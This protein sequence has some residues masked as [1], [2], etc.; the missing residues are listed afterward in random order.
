[1]SGAETRGLNPMYI[2]LVLVTLTVCAFVP[3][4]AG[5]PSLAEVSK[6]REEI[7]RSDALWLLK[8]EFEEPEAVMAALMER[9]KTRVNYSL[10]Q[11]GMRLCR[12][13]AIYGRAKQDPRIVAAA[14]RFA[15]A[16]LRKHAT[17]SGAFVEYDRNTWL[18]S[19]E[20]W[21]TIPWGTAFCGNRAFEAWMELKTDFTPEERA[22]WRQS[23]EK[24][25]RWIHRNPVLGGYVFNNVI[26]LCG[27]LWRIGREFDHPEW[28]RAALEVAERRIR[29]DVDEEGWIQGENGG[30][31]GTYQLIGAR[32]LSQFAWEAKAPVL[33][34]AVRRIFARSAM[35]YATPTLEWTGNFGTRS[36]DLRQLPGEFV[37]AAAAFGEPA[38][39]YYVQTY[40]HASWSADLALWQAA[41][42]QQAAAP[43]YPAVLSFKG[44]SSTVV[45][46]GPWIA[47]FGNYNRSVWA[48]GFASL[49]HAG[50]GDWVFSTLNSLQLLSPTEKAKARVGDLSD[51]SG[52]PHVRV[53]NGSAT[54]DSHRQIAAIETANG[55]GVTV[56]WIEPLLDDAGQRGGE[57]Q[58]SYHFRGSEID[59]RLDLRDLAGAATLDFHG[60]RR[61]NGFVRLWKAREVADILAGGFPS[62]AGDF[63]RRALAPAEPRLLAMQIDRTVFA[64]EILE[65]PSVA[66]VELLGEAESPMH[67]GN[68]GG[69]RLRISVPASE[70]NVTIKLRVRATE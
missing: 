50:H 28:C 42:A 60:L 9:R 7:G 54:Y 59:L 49:W 43:V 70:K 32:Y 19:S 58:S 64:F 31:S 63:Q 12:D 45:R 8:H 27:L 55:D 34:D 25:G 65:T 56:R 66:T 24:T 2:R 22:F 23:F 67:T 15:D 11:D 21:R 6:V 5:A 61:P 4:H 69:F 51:W 17:P 18:K 16:L 41:L 68:L 33:I 48:R 39:A 57:L 35:F 20:M 10:M 30:A 40:S 52:F 62:S 3:L 36:S 53:S 1:M 46:E 29:R 13:V 38:A 14:A 44:I 37:L 47:Y 26:D